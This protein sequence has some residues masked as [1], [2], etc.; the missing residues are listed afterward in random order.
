MGTDEKGNY[1]SS[2]DNASGHPN[3]G[4]RDLNKLY[5]ND[6]TGIIQGQSQTSYSQETG[7]YIV[8]QVRETK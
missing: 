8:S 6:K 5:Y 4:T 2:Y 7:N 3:E 1:F